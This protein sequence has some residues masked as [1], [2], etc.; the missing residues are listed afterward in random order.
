MKPGLLILPF[1]ALLVA[2]LGTA[3]GS[4]LPEYNWISQTTWALVATVVGLWVALDFDNFKALFRRKGSKYGAS[5]GLV[6]ILGT[7][8]IVGIAIVA[9]RPRFNKSVDLSRDKLN[10]LSDQSIKIIKQ[11]K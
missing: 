8:V 3:A 10:T 5:S 7:V 1:L 6:V 9:A 4:A 2:A 11:V